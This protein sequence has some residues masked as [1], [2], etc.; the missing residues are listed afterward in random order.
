M[1]YAY[2]MMMRG[3]APKCQPLDGLVD[4]IEDTSESFCDILIYSRKLRESEVADYE[5]L[6]LG[7]VD[8]E[9]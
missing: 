4:A 8:Y 6:Y 9:D 7:E 3:F 1:Q 5:L 2:G